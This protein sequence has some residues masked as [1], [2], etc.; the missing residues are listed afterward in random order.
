MISLKV[1][2]LTYRTSDRDLEYLFEKY[3]K[4]KSIFELYSSNIQGPHFNLDWRH[5]HSTRQVQQGK[6]W[7]C[8]CQV[9]ILQQGF[10]LDFTQLLC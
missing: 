3:G 5:L 7:I 6:S 1:D 2:N 4:V 10:M 9:N 8:L